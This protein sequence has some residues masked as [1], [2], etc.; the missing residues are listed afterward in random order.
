MVEKAQFTAAAAEL[1]RRA[2][3]AW[4]ISSICDRKNTASYWKSESRA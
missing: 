3:S 1:P 4:A 2:A